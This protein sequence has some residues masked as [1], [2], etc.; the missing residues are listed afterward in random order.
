MVVAVNKIDNLS[1]ESFAH[2]FHSLGFEQLV[3]VSAIQD[4]HIA[5]LLE[6]LCPQLPES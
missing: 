4:L 2:E 3:P 6:A 1:H 5:E